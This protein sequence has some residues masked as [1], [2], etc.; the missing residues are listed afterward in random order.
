VLGKKAEQISIKTNK[1]TK[2]NA[3]GMDEDDIQWRQGLGSNEL[4]LTTAVSQTRQNRS[5]M[6][7]RFVK[8][9]NEFVFHGALVDPHHLII[10]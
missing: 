2:Y 3:L 10:F 8:Q 4:F 5:A 6:G 1:M 7:H 9:G